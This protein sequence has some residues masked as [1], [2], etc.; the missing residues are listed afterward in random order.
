MTPKTNSTN[1]DISN[2]PESTGHLDRIPQNQEAQLA[3]LDEEQLMRCVDL[4]PELVLEMSVAE[5]QEQAQ[6]TLQSILKDTPENSVSSPLSVSKSARLSLTGM[7][8]AGREEAEVNIGRSSKHAM[9]DF[10]HLSKNH[11]NHIWR[12]GRWAFVL[13]ALM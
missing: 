8:S 9:E 10:R 2:L 4:S 7:Y 6:N 1:R 11:D 12:Q 3:Q 13:E 5:A